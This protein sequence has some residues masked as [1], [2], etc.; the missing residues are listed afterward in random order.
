[1]S[2]ESVCF[3]VVL[4]RIS[5]SATLSKKGKNR[6]VDGNVMLGLMKKLISK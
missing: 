5:Y 4:G 1:M 2:Y 3:G 6:G